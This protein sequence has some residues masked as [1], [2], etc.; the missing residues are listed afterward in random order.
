MKKLSEQKLPKVEMDRMP[1]REALEFFCAKT[2]VNL[3]AK[4]VLEDEKSDLNPPV[5][6]DIPKLDVAKIPGVPGALPGKSP[7]QP[8]ITIHRQNM[9]LNEFLDEFCQ[10]SGLKWVIEYPGFVRII[11]IPK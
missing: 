9:P 10:Q 2:R 3:V 7:P 1:L 8:L 5:A 6:G 4:F 11:P